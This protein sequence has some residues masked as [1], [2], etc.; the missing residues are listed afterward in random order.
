MRSTLIRSAE[1]FAELRVAWDDL[2]E[3]SAAPTVFLTWEWL[4][5]WWDVYGEGRELRVVAVWDGDR[6]VG[7]A[8]LY[9]EGNRRGELRLLSDIEV[10]ADFIGVVCLAGREDDVCR[11]LWEAFASRQWCRLVLDHV[12]TGS[13]TI[14]TIVSLAEAGGCRVH[15]YPRFPCPSM[16]LPDRWEAFLDA[17]DRT[18]KHIVARRLRKLKRKHDVEVIPDAPAAELSHYI[19]TLIDLHTERWAA[20]GK[21]GSFAG[22]E[23]ERFYRL[24]APLLSARG[25]LRLSAL[26]VDG[27]VEAIEFGMQFGA[28]Y[29]SL[30]C[31]CSA[32]GLTLKA[33]NVLMCAVFE[34]LVGEVRRFEY[35][36]GPES[37][38]YRWGCRD[39]RWTECVCISRGLSGAVVS[40]REVIAARAKRT[41]KRLLNRR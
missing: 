34:A 33:G 1:Q 41:A 7:A 36:R 4:S 30:Q 16:E 24:V 27:V 15:R 22:S 13:R 35:L 28:A 8:P 26:R 17:P 23:M 21:P 10:G 11:C 18:F 40:W 2:V 6:L 12:S 37:Y 31:G 38:K 25:W 29:Y 9:S 32:R 19:D 5:A 20:L 14:E 3:R 39:D